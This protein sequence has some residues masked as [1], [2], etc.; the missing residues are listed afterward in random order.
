MRGLFTRRLGKGVTRTLLTEVESVLGPAPAS[1]FL[2]EESEAVELGL[3]FAA[4]E[5]EG[6][7]TRLPTDPMPVLCQALAGIEA[8]LH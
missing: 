3:S 4:A 1:R 5:H 7:I 8:Q 2:P 6:N